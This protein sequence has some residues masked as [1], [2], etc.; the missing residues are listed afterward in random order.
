VSVHCACAAEAAHATLTAAATIR[1]DP[2]V[3]IPMSHPLR[4]AAVT[5]GTT[6][7]L[8]SFGM[9]AL[10][11]EVSQPPLARGCGGANRA[12]AASGPAGSRGK[13]G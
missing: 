2:N 12:N 7:M 4:G 1:H 13:R 8:V 10:T 9:D 6:V 3:R 11:D 5:A